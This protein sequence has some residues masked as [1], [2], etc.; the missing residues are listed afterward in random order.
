[1]VKKIYSTTIDSKTFFILASGKGE[2]INYLASIIGQSK[3]INFANLENL[4]PNQWDRHYITDP[5]TF[6]FDMDIPDEEKDL[7]S[8]CELIIESFTQ[9]AEREVGPQII[10]TLEVC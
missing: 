2:A 3:V 7:Y 9:Y 5:F 4:H 10:K 6:S 8:N 1:M